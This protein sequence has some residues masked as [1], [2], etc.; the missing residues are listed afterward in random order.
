M[1]KIAIIRIRGKIGLKKG[2]K[3]TLNLLRLFN[4]HTCVVVDGNEN[5]SGMIKKVKDY[6][7]WGEIDSET[8]K[9]L[10]QKR[11]KLPGK[12]NLTEEY[13]KDKSKLSYD[14]FVNEFFEFKKKMKD[15]PGLKQFFKLK[16]P[17]KG[18]ERKGIKQPFSLGGVLGYRKE[19]INDLIRKM[20]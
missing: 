16:P 7:T 17:E 14:D 5:Y 12:K 6:V 18:F 4:K 10:L 1:K 20:L 13:L 3:D 8:F 15:V 9:L 11:G 19:K 2:I